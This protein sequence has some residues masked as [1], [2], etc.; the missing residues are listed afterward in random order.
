[1]IL[2][3]NAAAARTGEPPAAMMAPSRFNS[4]SDHGCVRTFISRFQSFAGFFK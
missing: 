1:M 3:F 2:R 4:S